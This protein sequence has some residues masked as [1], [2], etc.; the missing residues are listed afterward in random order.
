MALTALPTW[1][2]GPLGVLSHILRGNYSTPPTVPNPDR[3]QIGSTSW[4]DTSLGGD[5]QE[6][7]TQRAES[8]PTSRKYQFPQNYPGLP[9]FRA[10]GKSLQKQGQLLKVTALGL[11]VTVEGVET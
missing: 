11:V 9:G 2:H 5:S 4:P 1:S 8:S 3:T 10:I 6:A 7:E